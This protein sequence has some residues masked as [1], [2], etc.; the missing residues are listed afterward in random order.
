[1]DPKTKQEIASAMRTQASQ[2][3]EFYSSIPDNV[4]FVRPAKGWSA[5][6]N[7]RHLKKAAQGVLVGMYTPKA[8]LRVIFGK[9]KKPPRTAVQLKELYLRK[10]GQGA[11]AGLFSPINKGGSGNALKKAKLIES[12][13]RAT[14]SLAKSL[15]RFS[16]EELDQLRL[17]HP[18]LG[19]LAIREM[20]NFGLF[21]NEHHTGIVR[22]R[23]K[24]GN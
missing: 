24:K 15:D 3:K 6:G 19:M 21:H 13:S 18:I 1:M 9:S 11:G 22:E 12:F 4:F 7:V 17:P 10:L 14:E 23:M 8:I 2:L 5:A 20:I 16:E